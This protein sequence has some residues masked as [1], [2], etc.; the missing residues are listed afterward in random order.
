MEFEDRFR[1]LRRQ[2][3]RRT[4]SEVIKK[5][6]ED[7]AKDA[8]VS[9]R[10]K[11][12]RLIRLTRETRPK[13]EPTILLEPRRRE[14]LQVFENHFPLHS[15]YGRVAIA[16]GLKI[17]SKTLSLLSRDRSFEDLSL[18]CALFLDLE[19]TGLSGGVGVVP[20]LVGLGFYGQDDF[21]IVQFFLGDLAAEEQLIHELR[22]FLGQMNFRSVVT[23]NGKAFDL[24]ILETRFILHRESLALSE[25]PH[26]DFLFVARGLWG[27]K[28]ESCRLYHLAREVLGA[29]RGE[30]IPSAEIPARYFQFLRSGDFGLI[31]PV[32]YHNQEDILSLLGIVVVGAGLLDEELE[33]AG[34]CPGDALDFFGVAK[35]LEKTGEVERSA[36]FIQRALESGLTGKF[37]VLAKKKLAH[38]FKQNQ[39][40]EEAVHLWQEMTPLGQLFC[41]RELAIYYEHREKDYAKARQLAEEGLVL[42]NGISRV[43]ERDF[44]RRLERLSQKLAK[45]KTP[46][47]EK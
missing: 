17:K 16:S 47:G 43:Y 12:E 26:L 41:F 35:I 22:L 15:K 13:K 20:F 14:P 33:V 39:N 37:S 2:G 5:T 18:S 7:I 29:E 10:E 24:P 32:L 28:H 30:D 3:P 9:T 36:Q 23:F 8:E 21:H 19:T 1:P 4:R 25:L 38:Y 27:H 45:L 6:W 34:E 46:L 40:W 44:S 42:S 31:E 11:L